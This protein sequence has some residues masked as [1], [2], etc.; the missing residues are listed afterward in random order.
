MKKEVTEWSW[1]KN[2]VMLHEKLQHF[3]TKRCPDCPMQNTAFFIL[4]PLS[5]F[6]VMKK[7][8]GEE[9]DSKKKNVEEENGKG[10]QHRI[11]K[12]LWESF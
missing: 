4:S 6:S 11:L 5:P 10:K 9:V 12:S 8:K 2:Q 3:L 1:Q 7:G